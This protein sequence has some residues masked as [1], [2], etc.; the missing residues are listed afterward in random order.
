M[1][2]IKTVYETYRTKPL[3]QTRSEFENRARLFQFLQLFQSF[4]QVKADF[5]KLQ[6]D[7]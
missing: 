2:R 4:I 6:L 5:A 7:K 1:N 3:P